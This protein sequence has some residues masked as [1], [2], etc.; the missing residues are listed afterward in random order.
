MAIF[1]QVAA[2]LSIVVLAII[3]FKVAPLNMTAK[4]IT[5]VTMLVVLSIVLQFFSI[6]VPLF[7][8]PSLRLDFLHIPLMFIGVLFGPGW[9]LIGGVIQDAIGLIVTPTGF[10]FFGFTLNKVLMGV[11]PGFLFLNAKHV[12]KRNIN[13]I[14]YGLLLL[15]L[16]GSLM[17]LWSTNDIVIEGNIIHITTL[18]KVALSLFNIVLV[19]GLIFLMS[20]LQ[21]RYHPLGGLLSLWT[22][23]TLLVE[24]S[25]T[26]VFTPTW[27]YAMYKIPVMLSFLVRVIKV[28]FMIP[29]VMIIG[30]GIMDLLA[31]MKLF[32]VVKEQ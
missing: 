30:Y 31:R 10:P 14:V 24:V 17:H 22:I 25:I 9:A 29:L 15:F 8:F 18:I 23:A 26:L 5:I 6:M 20:W 3:S 28:S 21:K 19:V 7:G 1:L 4:K 13:P 12:A 32:E 16:V 11:I 27:L 2:F